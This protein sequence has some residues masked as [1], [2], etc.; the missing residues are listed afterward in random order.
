MSPRAHALT[1]VALTALAGACAADGDALPAPTA[2]SPSTVPASTVPA[3]TVP[4]STAIAP[5][6]GFLTAITE[7]GYPRDLLQRGRVNVETTNSGDVALRVTSRELLIDY[8]RSPGPEERRSLIAAG[9][10]IDL[11]TAHGEVV[12]CVATEPITA[13]AVLEY[14]EEGDDTERVV[15]VPIGD[16]AIL[17]TVRT[18]VCTARALT[19]AFTLTFSDPVID[20]ETLTTTL[21]LERRADSPVIVLDRAFGTVLFGVERSDASPSTIEP[22]DTSATADLRFDV[23]RC[24]PHAVAETTKKFGLQ[25]QVAIDGAEPVWTEVDVTPLHASLDRILDTCKQRTGQ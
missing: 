25:L 13:V 3:S 10:T 15:A 23:N 11:Q 19:D 4:A 14:H 9:A 1:V 17:E 2:P 21:R 6:P 7:A 24:D 16:T 18:R 8:F 20:G 12:D 5:A 22:G